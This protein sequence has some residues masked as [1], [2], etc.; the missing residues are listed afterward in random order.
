MGTLGDTG[1]AGRECDLGK[2]LGH[3]AAPQYLGIFFF[4]YH[5]ALEHPKKWAKRG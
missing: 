4:F 1:A 3:D 5:P 2:G